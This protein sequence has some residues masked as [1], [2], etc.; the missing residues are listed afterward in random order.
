VVEEARVLVGGCREDPTRWLHTK[1]PSATWAELLLERDLKPSKFG[2]LTDH[3]TGNL[4]QRS[5]QALSGCDG[6]RAKP[7]GASTY[8]DN[9]G[10]ATDNGSVELNVFLV[11]H[12]QKGT[13]RR[14]R[15]RLSGHNQETKP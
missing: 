15:I 10:G 5:A 11:K 12:C 14:R 9:H 3:L 4:L 13:D 8:C 6:I 7:N 2:C 1:R